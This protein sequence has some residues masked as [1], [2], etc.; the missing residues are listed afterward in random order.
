MVRTTY[1]QCRCYLCA[2]Y[3]S[4]SRLPVLVPP[5]NPL[6]TTIAIVVIVVGV[7]AASVE[8]APAMTAADGFQI[9]SNI[10][11]GT[12]DFRSA[13]ISLAYFHGMYTSDMTLIKQRY[14]AMK[15]HSMASFFD[16][17]AGLLVK[18]ADADCPA[19]WSPLAGLPKGVYEALKPKCGDLIDWPSASRDGYVSNGNNRSAVPNAYAAVALSRLA[20]MAGWLGDTAGQQQ[21]QRISSTIVAS[22]KSQMYNPSTGNVRDGV[23]I[24]HY[25][26]HATMFAAV[27]GVAD[28][29]AAMADKLVNFIVSKGGTASCSCMGAYWLLEALYRLAVDSAAAAVAALDVITSSGKNSWLHM[30]Q[31]GA[32]STMEAWTPDEKPNLTWSHP[33]CSSPNNVL[34][35]LLLGLQPIEPGWKRLQVVPQPASLEDV[36]VVAATSVGPIEVQVSQQRVGG[37]GDLGNLPGSNITVADAGSILVTVDVPKGSTARVC[38]PPAFG[39]ELSAARSLTL[40]GVTVPSTVEGR[41]LCLA[42]DA[43]SGKHTVVRA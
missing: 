17:D 13:L 30:I 15:L 24:E 23:G 38:L 37:N 5:T 33:W 32:T 14:T 36:H 31:Q 10:W 21:W 1:A 35:R 27:A 9:D 22:M 18:L 12:L 2:T 19:A 39:T 29:D 42:T 4:S 41:L 28:G 40:D 26:L 34:I 16:A 43:G 20:V 6:I 7:D 11:Q 8:G 3:F 25:S